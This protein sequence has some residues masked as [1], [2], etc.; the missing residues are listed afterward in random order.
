MAVINQTIA[1]QAPNTTNPAAFAASAPT[2]T[3]AQNKPNSIPLQFNLVATVTAATTVYLPS[4]DQIA[5][6]VSGL[7]TALSGETSTAANSVFLQVQEISQFG[8]NPNTD[9]NDGL[10]SSEF[11][12]DNT[13][14]TVTGQVVLTTAAAFMRRVQQSPM[15][16]TKIQMSTAESTSI[17]TTMYGSY[18]NLGGN[19]NFTL[20]LN[21]E[22]MVSGNNTLYANYQKWWLT[23]GT[24]LRAVCPAAGTYRWTFF[25]AGYGDNFSDLTTL[26]IG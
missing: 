18:G 20:Q 24:Q 14:N 19:T 8:F 13:A 16:I 12:Y 23:G 5:E 1:Q 7:P 2:M 26:P 11:V 9:A 15:Y 25:V 3:C 4:F 22:S 10:A 6:L 21:A 17:I